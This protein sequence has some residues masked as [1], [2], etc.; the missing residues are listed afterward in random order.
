VK[1]CN[2]CG[3][4]CT[5]Y[6]AGGLSVSAEE[7]DWWET[8]RP[9][10]AAYVRGGEIWF[11]PKTGK[12][13][14]HC[15]WLRK[16]PNQEK[17]TCD[18]YFDRPDECRQYPVTIEEMLRDGCEMLEPKDLERPKKAQEQLDLLMAD[19]RPPLQQ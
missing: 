18:I 10:I 19:S 3:K 6:G 14:L 7:I 12:P 8:H 1:D 15:P 9:D 13:M 4:C 2:Q 5:L 11:S 16:L 17:Y